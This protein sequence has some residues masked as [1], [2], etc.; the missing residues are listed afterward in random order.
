MFA[1]RRSSA[2]ALPGRYSISILGLKGREVRSDRTFCKPHQSPGA[3]YRVDYACSSCRRR[4]PSRCL[5]EARVAKWIRSSLARSAGSPPLLHGNLRTRGH[6]APPKA[7][8]CDPLALVRDV[9]GSSRPAGWNRTRSISAMVPSTL[10][11]RHRRH[12]SSAG[13]GGGDYYAPRV[14]LRAARELV[15]YLKRSGGQEQYSG[16]ALSRW[17]R[18]TRSPPS[19]S[20]SRSHLPPV[21]PWK[22]SLGVRALSSPVLPP[23]PEA[24]RQ[25][26]WPFVEDLRLGQARERL[27]TSTTLSESLAA[28]VGFSEPG[29]PSAGLSRRRY[30]LP[31]TAYREEICGL[32]PRPRT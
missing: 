32:G 29:F 19:A 18:P 26:P 16:P 21:F 5:G 17:R 1:I 7:E 22:H 25:T 11:G 10:G 28:S 4:R 23:V 30:G 24:F 13:P 3:G 8:R 20:G 9:A 2:E 15:V 12:R 31:P 6:R 27:A 14:A